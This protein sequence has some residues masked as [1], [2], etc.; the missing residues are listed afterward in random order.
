MKESDTKDYSEQLEFLNSQP[1]YA[2]KKIVI[3]SSDFPVRRTGLYR[4]KKST[5]GLCTEY[6]QSADGYYYY[7]ILT[8]ATS[9]S[10]PYLVSK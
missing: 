1:Y 8:I 10:I 6:P 4:H 9:I 5:V 2:S 3:Q 7:T